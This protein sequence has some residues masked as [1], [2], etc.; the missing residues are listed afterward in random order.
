MK[1]A[2]IG[3]VVGLAIG[4]GVVMMGQRGG[5]NVPVPRGPDIAKAGEL[6]KRCNAPLGV[7]YERVVAPLRSHLASEP[8]KALDAAR[9]QVANVIEIRLGVC[10]QALAARE[11]QKHRG[12]AG[13]DVYRDI[14][15]LTPFVEKLTVART[16][17][18]ELI[19][20]LSSPNGSD[21]QQKLDA[22]DA[23]MRD[24]TGSAGSATVTTPAAAGSAR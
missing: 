19:A 14:A 7:M 3:V 18:D 15:Q 24:A 17:L 5:D 12:S 4:V 23:A 20:T 21:A 11:A 1:Q 10:Q 2:V 6:V 9:G 16:R 8:G 22:L 13:P